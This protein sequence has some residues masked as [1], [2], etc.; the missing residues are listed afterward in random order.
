MKFTIDRFEGEWALVELENKD[1]VNIPSIIL[2][3][4]AKEG[5]IVKIIIDEKETEKRRRRIQDKFN[6]LFSG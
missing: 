2:P 4:E 6:D 3:K 5:D 1:I